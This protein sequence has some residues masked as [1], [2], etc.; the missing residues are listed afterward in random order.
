MWPICPISH[1]API[2]HTVAKA[3]DYAIPAYLSLYQVH[4][5][6][7]WVVVT[8]RDFPDLYGQLIS[9]I[10]LQLSMKTLSEWE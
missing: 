1:L 5:P 8:A 3:T 4:G 6:C 2:S 9:E 7:A 10:F